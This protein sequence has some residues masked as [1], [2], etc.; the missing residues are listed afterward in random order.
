MKKGDELNKL[1]TYLAE[2]V[3]SS[4]EYLAHDLERV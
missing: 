2:E 4:K 1:L 3:D